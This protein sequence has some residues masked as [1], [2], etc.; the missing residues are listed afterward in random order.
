MT[1]PGGG[2]AHMDKGKAPRRGIPKTHIWGVNP[3]FVGMG[4][5]D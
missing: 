2:N 1:V 4:A 3:A 5:R